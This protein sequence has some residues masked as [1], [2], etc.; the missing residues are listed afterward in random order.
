MDDQLLALSGVVLVGGCELRVVVSRGALS[1]KSGEGE[2]MSLFPGKDS[3]GDSAYRKGILSTYG[4]F[5][6]G[7]VQVVAYVGTGDETAVRV[8]KY[9][10]AE[11]VFRR[12][13]ERDRGVGA[14]RE[15]GMV[16]FVQPVG[17]RGGFPRVV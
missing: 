12:G 10:I 1:Q 7:V 14:L 2:F 3:A 6:G 11:A 4:G 16:V 8:S 15:L 5:D 13:A 17:E 9:G